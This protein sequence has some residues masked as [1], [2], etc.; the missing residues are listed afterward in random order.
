MKPR[1]DA[2]TIDRHAEMLANRVRKNDKKLRRGFER[3][4]VDVYRLYD[5][6]IPEVR[7][8]VD[9]YADHLVLA[10]Y[11]R[12]QTADAPHYGDALARAAGEA[13]AI[14]A[15]HLHVKKRRTRP[16]AGARYERLEERETRIEV[17]ERALRFLVNLDDYV[18]TGLFGDHRETRRMIGEQSGGL[19]V[20]NLFG[21]TGT[22]TC[23][24]AH[25]GAART[26]TVEAN[27]RYVAW[28]RDNL[29]LNG[30]DDPKH[31]LVTG[32]VG[33]FIDGAAAASFDLVIV[34]PPS[35]STRFGA[36][37]FDVQ[38]DHRALLTRVARVVAPGGRALFSTNHQRFEPWIEGLP[39]ARVEEI[40]ERT[41]PV[42]YRNRTVHRAFWLEAPES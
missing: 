3:E 18:D 14:P 32:D 11:E 16:K 27:P 10:V 41:V 8:V 29:E 42:D 25:G 38:R 22:F 20:L 2:A 17:R 5:R 37:D 7:A 21:Y 4:S 12:T 28:T 23:W 24:A 1:M 36:G 30:L 26:V 9:R 13:L 39:F 34:D 35:F 19:R 33:P 31:E 40:T 6:D 15:A